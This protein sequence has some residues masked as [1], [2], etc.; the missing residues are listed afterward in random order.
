VTTDAPAR[1]LD[2]ALRLWQREI[3]AGLHGQRADAPGTWRCDAL[4]HAAAWERAARDLDAQDCGETAARCR[5][6]ARQV[7]RD[8]A[9]TGQAA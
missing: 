2:P 9:R 5:A 8:A 6:T 3:R 7:I 4:W 1:H